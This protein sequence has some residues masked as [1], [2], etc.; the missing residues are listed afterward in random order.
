MAL[1]LPK[2]PA[3]QKKLLIGL[4]PI[5][6]LGGY[7]QFMH[8]GANGKA[9]EV[10]TLQ[11][12]YDELSAKNDQA[13]AKTSPAAVRDMRQKLDLWQQ[14]LVQLEELIPQ[15]EEV[16]ALLYAMSE[17]AS[18][19]GIDLVKYTPEGEEQQNYYTQQTYAVRVVGTYHAIGRFLAM[20][21]SL[22]RIITATEAR[23]SMPAVLNQNRRP[24]AAPRLQ[25]DFKIHT[26]IIPPTEA[27]TPTTPTANAGA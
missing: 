4:L 19:A 9:A 3:G 13:R 25:L 22:P 12:R 15:R 8:A 1:G 17:R 18:Q 26:Y 21:G 5:L 14:H 23:L 2:D 10:E 24:E 20:T 7:Y 27:T 11:T 16:P 6:L